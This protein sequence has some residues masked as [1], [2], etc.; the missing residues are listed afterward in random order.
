MVIL[1]RSGR[2]P[3]IEEEGG[4]R[5]GQTHMT[6][7]S[8]CLVYALTWNKIWQQHVVVV[9]VVVVVVTTILQYDLTTRTM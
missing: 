7:D 2:E 3:F 9:V 8:V 4:G 1:L 5:E 6:F